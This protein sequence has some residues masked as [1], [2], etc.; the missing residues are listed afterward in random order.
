MLGQPE[1]AVADFRHAISLRPGLGEA[2]WYIADLKTARFADSDIV[3]MRTHAGNPAL[4]AA[5]RV[6]LHF[7]LG[8]AFEDRQDWAASF[9]EYARGASL[10]RA[11]NP[12]DADAHT[13]SVA[14]TIAES[15]ADFFADRAAGGEEDG[16]P[17]FIVGLPRA[18]S[19]LLEQI[20]GRHP[21]IEPTTELS[22]IAHMV[23]ALGRPGRKGTGAGYGVAL[24]G[25][26]GAERRAL[27]REY[28][29][30][31]A[32]YR[33]TDKPH[34][35]DK[36]PSNFL[37]AGFI[38][39]I[40]PRARIIDMRRQPM[41]ACFAAFK[42]H[43]VQGHAFSYDLADAGRYYRDYVALMAHMD[44]VLPGLVH[45][46]MYEDL[47]ANPEAE[48]R[49]VLDFLGLPFDAACLRHWEGAGP[50]V[51]HSSE[52]VRQPIYRGSMELWR[53]YEPWLGALKAALA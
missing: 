30:R 34:F 1:A 32:R 22:A 26:T 3:A 43:F 10:H 51:T 42:Q 33:R 19:T 23:G 14:L 18:G 47:V 12:Y 28:L 31:T 45:R 38:R 5:N 41:A 39:L 15:P 35:I 11:A 50:I 37:H 21:A 4:T 24:A 2:W 8:K 36:M 48:I 52:Q 9:T 13:A 44:V 17:I 27:G 46:V 20:L 25:L 53:Q 7:A 6:N 40:L 16:A 49:R 29:H